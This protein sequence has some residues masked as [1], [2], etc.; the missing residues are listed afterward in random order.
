M[1]CGMVG[2]LVLVSVGS[3]TGTEYC[4]AYDILVG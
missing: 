2:V 3:N 4:G 1:W